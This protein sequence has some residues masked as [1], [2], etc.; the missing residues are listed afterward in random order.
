[1]QVVGSLS[2]SPVSITNIC[3]ALHSA[4]INADEFP[5]QPQTAGATRRRPHAILIL[6]VVNLTNLV[7]TIVPAPVSQS[8][9]AGQAAF[10]H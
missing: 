1:M 2:I 5:E 6:I 4:E 3:Q 8:F 10:L 9:P 7:T